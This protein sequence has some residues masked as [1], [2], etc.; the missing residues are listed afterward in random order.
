M[1]A[2]ELDRLPSGVCIDAAAVAAAAA[3]VVSCNCRGETGAVCCPLLAASVGEMD[4]ASDEA[5]AVPGMSTAAL[6]L[7]LRARALVVG[8][9][10]RL[11]AGL[12]P[13][14]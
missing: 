10:G 4:R 11:K 5:G 14:A 2:E 9:E 13:A 3:L 8:A 12:G 1:L 6:S 7:M